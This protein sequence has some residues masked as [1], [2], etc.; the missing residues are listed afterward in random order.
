V[1]K[2]AS[3]PSPTVLVMN[4]Y[5]TGLGIAR[6]LRGLRVPIVALSSEA[7]IPGARSRYFNQVLMAPN[8][9]DEP[10]A[11][12]DFLVKAGAGFPCKPVVFPTRDFDVIFLERFH[13]ALAPWYV[14]PQP[15]NSQILR[16]MDK[17]ELASVAMKL[18]LPTP[19]TAS[20][21]SAESLEIQA[22][23]M[24]FPVIAKPRYAFQWRQQGLWEKVGAQKAF[25]VDSRED[26]RRL[27]S[28]LAAVTEEVLLQEYIP[29]VDMDIVVCCV[30]IGR[31]G[32]PKGHFTG[33]KL[34]Q[35]PP[36]VGTGCVVEAVDCPAIVSPT[37]ALLNAFGY[38]GI[39]E[40]EFKLDKATGIYYLIEINPRHWD[41]HELGTLV[42]INISRL[43]YEDMLGRAPQSILPTYPAGSRCVW[44]AER[45]L[46]LDLGRSVLAAIRAVPASG[47]FHRGVAAAALGWRETSALLRGRRIYSMS[48]LSDPL[49]GVNEG[50]N[51]AKDV[52][53]A[54]G[55]QL[56][57]A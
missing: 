2:P 28:R 31:D 11:L 43:A 55:R 51:L 15:D 19:R 3:T 52:F 47:R 49:P 32:K 50:W 48:R 18:G 7:N 44:V 23:T 8:G 17:L 4:P 33:R 27:Y 14:L 30:Y 12:C 13:D 34:K 29:G 1:N 25:I 37:F 40:V 20:C 42:G 21:D 38:T 54:V 41:Q 46:A 36:L 10:E 6:A 39:A 56:R 22:S 53:L 24:R 16:M 45:E 26:L 9:R 35:S 57:K 5:Y